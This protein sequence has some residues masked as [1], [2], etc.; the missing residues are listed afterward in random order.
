ME[1][2]YVSDDGTQVVAKDENNDGKLTSDETINSDTGSFQ[3]DPLPEEDKWTQNWNDF[4]EN[5]TKEDGVLDKAKTTILIILG[6]GLLVLIGY[7]IIRIIP[8]VKTNKT[9]TY[10]NKKRKG[11][12][13]K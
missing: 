11:K 2:V 13:R 7:G 6:V 9:T 4:I 10:K 3:G 12:K 5:L 8:L 1:E